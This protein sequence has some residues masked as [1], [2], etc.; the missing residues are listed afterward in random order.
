M[1]YSKGDYVDTVAAGRG[2]NVS[3]YGTTPYAAGEELI[4]SSV[5]SDGRLRVRKTTGGYVF[6]IHPKNVTP[7]VREIGDVPEGGIDM[8]DPRIQWIFEDAARLANRSGYCNMYDR[9][10]EQLGAPGRKR[11]ITVEIPTP[12]GVT[13]RATVEATSKAA[14]KKLVI[15]SLAA[16]G[17]PKA[18]EA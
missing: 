6:R 5:M 18:L 15:A 1:T 8:D 3:Q 4:V 7:V 2:D 9:L 13:M 14:A 17:G 10:A 12:G 11:R 16:A